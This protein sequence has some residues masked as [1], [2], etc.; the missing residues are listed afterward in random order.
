MLR[1]HQG[2]WHSTVSLLRT[3]QEQPAP[4][5]TQGEM[6]LIMHLYMHLIFITGVGRLAFKLVKSS[7]GKEKKRAELSVSNHS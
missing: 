1:S 5:A 3:I 6:T 4:L 7:T 2:P